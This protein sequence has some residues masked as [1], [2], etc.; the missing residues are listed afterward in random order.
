MTFSLLN[1]LLHNFYRGVMMPKIN[2]ITSFFYS[3]AIVIS[4]YAMIP[5]FGI[6]GVFYAYN[7]AWVT[8][9]IAC[10]SIYLS[11]KWKSKAYKDAEQ[12]AQLKKAA[13]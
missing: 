9:F 4:A 13:I 11:R 2:S 3:A 10:L 1:N 8:E 7:V 12:K 5:H 6:Y